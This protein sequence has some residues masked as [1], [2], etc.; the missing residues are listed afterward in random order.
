M[1]SKLI[2]SALIQRNRFSFV[3]MKIDPPF[4]LSFV[5]NLN[6]YSFHLFAWK[7]M[8]TL[9]CF[10]YMFNLYQLPSLLWET[11]SITF[12]AIDTVN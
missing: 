11:K 8:L 7:T 12:E 6:N 4:M 2:D 3:K 5:L 10:S 1:F 9:L